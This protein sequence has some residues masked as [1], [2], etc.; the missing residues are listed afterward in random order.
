[1]TPS[2]RTQV[3]HRK[4]IAQGG[5][6]EGVDGEPMLVAGVTQVEALAAL[7]QMPMKAA[8]GEDDLNDPCTVDAAIADR[9]YEA[10]VA[11][12]ARKRERRGRK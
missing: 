12:N 4:L 8:I 11:R 9:D 3:L 2:R 7:R 6:T 10:R 5:I 1:M